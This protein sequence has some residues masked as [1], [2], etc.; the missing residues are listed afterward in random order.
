MVRRSCFTLIVLIVF[1]SFAAAALK[2]KTRTT[3]QG[4]TSE[5]TVY[6]KGARERNE[7]SV[8]GRGGTATITQCDQKRVV[9]VMGDQ[10]MVMSMG[11]ESACP[12][13]PSMG[14]LMRGMPGGEPA[15]PR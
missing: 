4:H 10:C 9:T 14:S 3:V 7:M 2:I 11:G 13:R 15:A 6:I 12:V 1:S 8:G 5:S